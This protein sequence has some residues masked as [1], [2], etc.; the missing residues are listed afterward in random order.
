VN[1][2]AGNISHHL[3]ETISSLEAQLPAE[4]FMRISR[5]VIVNLDRIKELQPLFYGDFAAILLDG[6]R[7]TMS[8]NF[9]DRLERLLERRR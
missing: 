2:R 1:L 7:L 9:R 5:S 8:R 4:K 3:R 6:T